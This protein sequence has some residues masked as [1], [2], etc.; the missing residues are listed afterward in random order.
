MD[1]S[2]IKDALRTYIQTNLLH[3]PA[4]RLT[5]TEPLITGGLMDSFSLAQVAVFIENS[6]GVNLPDNDLTVE[7]MD[8]LE[9]MAARVVAGGPSGA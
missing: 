9:Q 3:D 1:P 2:T 6:F 7:N 4:Y 8:T 5:D